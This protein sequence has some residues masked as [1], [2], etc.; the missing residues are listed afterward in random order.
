MRGRQAEH[1]AGSVANEHAQRPQAGPKCGNPDPADKLH[2]PWNAAP[3]SLLPRAARQFPSGLIL[4]PSVLAR[5]KAAKVAWEDPDWAD[6]R[7][8]PENL[9]GYFSDN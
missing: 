6:R 3:W 2:F 9:T 7:Y 1:G 8:E 4:H 5:R